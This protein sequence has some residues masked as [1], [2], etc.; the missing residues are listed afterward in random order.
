MEKDSYQ[1]LSMVNP[2]DET[3]ASEL[4]LHQM[5]NF[6]SVEISKTVQNQ[7]IRSRFDVFKNDRMGISNRDQVLF[8]G[9]RIRKYF[10]LNLM[11]GQKKITG[12]M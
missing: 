5:N 3:T 9:E 8:D 10:E 1:T 7:V 11:V 2:F 12:D 4:S 6:F